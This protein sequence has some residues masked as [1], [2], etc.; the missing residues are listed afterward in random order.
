MTLATDGL[1]NCKAYRWTYA[2]ATARGAASG[3]A[4]A[5]VGALALQ[6]DDASLWILTDDSPATW[7]NVAGSAGLADPTTTKGDLMARS[8]SAVGRL[9]VG[10]NGQALV[11]DSAATLGVKWAGYRGFSVHKNTTVQ[12]IPSSGTFT[13]ITW[14][15][16]E[17]DTESA[18]ASDKHT[19]NIAGKYRQTVR[20]TFLIAGADKRAYVVLYKNGSR[21]R[22]AIG[23]NSISGGVAMTVTL[24]VI[25]DANG[26][27]D[28][29]E[30]YVNINEAGAD[31]EGDVL[32]TN[33]QC[34]YLGA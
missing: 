8:S 26:S 27:T 1:A 5:D 22:E 18:F 20:I 16:E 13:K 32:Q 7:V 34:Q 31:V 15:T 33:W 25:V 29:F 11:A 30:V 19:P 17:W 2:D 6:L 14:S 12:D 9:A 23:H 3:F 21:F 4:A 24:D 10:S 28:N